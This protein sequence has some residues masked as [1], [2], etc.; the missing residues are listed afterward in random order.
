M[1]R[2]LLIEDDS[3]F[4]SMLREALT[5]VGHEVTEAENGGVGLRT[6]AKGSFDLVLTDLVMPEVEGIETIVKLRKQCPNI[7]IIAM[8]GGGRGSAYDY[9]HIA[10]Q[11]GANRVLMKPFSTEDLRETVRTLTCTNSDTTGKNPSQS[12]STP[13]ATGSESH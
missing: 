13:A 11:I 9:L 6:F 7:R 4:R 3:L 12:S 8:S 1:A 10:Q 2:I 5:R